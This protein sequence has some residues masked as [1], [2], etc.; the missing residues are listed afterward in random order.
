MR[1]TGASRQITTLETSA[2]FIDDLLGAEVRDGPG[3]TDQPPAL[4]V[5]AID[6]ALIARSSRALSVGARCA[7]VVFVAARRCEPVNAAHS[8]LWQRQHMRARSHGI[9]PI[10]TPAAPKRT[11]AGTNEGGKRCN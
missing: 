4:H 7:H 3:R 1:Q 9:A 6:G 2:L 5:P 10:R 11:G 8:Q